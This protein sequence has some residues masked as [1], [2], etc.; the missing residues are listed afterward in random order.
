MTRDRYTDSAWTHINVPTESPLSVSGSFF[1]PG[2][3]L[4]HFHKETSSPTMFS[5]LSPSRF[6]HYSICHEQ[7]VG[8]W[9]RRG[10]PKMLTC[11]AYYY[12]VNFSEYPSPLY[13][14]ALKADFWKSGEPWNKN[15]FS[16]R[17]ETS[18]HP[19][20]DV[21]GLHCSGKFLTEWHL[22]REKKKTFF[23]WSFRVSLRRV[24][25]TATS[26]YTYI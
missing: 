16:S 22:S 25:V 7:Q 18:P 24:W 14:P 1:V 3:P 10:Q 26:R 9:F 5:F 23:L 6:F 12:D 4:P 15:G 19:T 20:L 2:P 11:I 13:G 8:S 17:G 21:D